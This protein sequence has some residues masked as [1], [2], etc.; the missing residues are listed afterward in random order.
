MRSRGLLAIAA[1]LALVRPV[2]AE[3][4]RGKIIDRTTRQPVAG[5]LVISGAELSVSADDGGFTLTLAP[6]AHT[7]QVT[8]DWLLPHS[9]SVKLAAGTTTDVTIDVEPAETA[10]EQIEVIDLAPSAVGETKV[11]A[12]FARAVPGGGDAGK[13]IQSLPAVARPSAGST[14]IVVWGAA[15]R[16]T[17]VFVDGVPVPALYHL[18]GY[19]SAVGND[20]IGDL[21]LSPAAFG[22]DRGRAIG[23]VIDIGLADPAKAPGWRVQADVLDASAEGKAKLGGLTVAA[24]VRQSWLDRAIALVSD[25]RKLAPNAPLPRWT[26]VQVVARAPFHD[27]LVLTTWVI[28]SLDRLDRTLASDDPATQTDETIDQRTVRAQV[29]LRRDRADG[30]DSGMVWLGRDRMTDDLQVGPIPANQAT[31][32]WVGGA[33]GVQQQRLAA[34]KV[35]TIGADLDGELAT[36]DRFGSLT[37][38]AREGDLHIFGQPPGDDVA[39]DRWRTTTVDAAGH[40]AIDVGAD[41]LSATFGL[42]L[43]GWL[44]T[45]SRLTPRVGTTPSIGS[46]QIDFTADPRGSLRY[47]LTDE[48]ALRADAGRYH[49]ARAANDTSAVFGTPSLGVEQAWHVTAG[50]QWRRAPIAFEIAGYARWLSDLVA[51]DLAVT[52]PLAKNLTQAGIGDVFGLQVTARVLGWRGLSGWL[53]YNLSRSRRK[54]ADDQPWRYFDHDQTHG[55]IAVAGWEHGAWN[56][57]GRVR[58]ATGEPR[59]DVLGAFFD[60]RTGRFEPIRGVHNG[61]RLPTYFAADVRGERKF[62]HG[63]VYIEVQNLTGRANAEEII[64]SADFSQRGYLT[65]LPLLAI[66]GVRIEQ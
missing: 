19:R 21:H 45:A 58:V 36:L 59:T 41:R 43:D 26:D 37:I 25:P 56:L 65:S 1:T 4:L 6:G 39:A 40:A 22:V 33:R 44:L 15:P 34:G 20:L 60:S 42:R 16:D 31:S 46:Q 53:S 29:T 7:I 38:P 49:Q 12:K 50:G 5:A 54:D 24:A 8:A 32:A 13:I 62:P 47:K 27:D 11:D 3:I 57:G 10:G 17:R 28:A 23:G 55:L 48:L 30:F 64:Y 14:E 52:P 35:L 66:A 61:V 51:R 63:A 2:A 18:G 9:S